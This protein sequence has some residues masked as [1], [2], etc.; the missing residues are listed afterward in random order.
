MDLHNSNVARSVQVKE[1]IIKITFETKWT[2]PGQ[3]YSI[4]AKDRSNA[5]RKRTKGRD[6]CDTIGNIETWLRTWCG[7]ATDIFNPMMLLLV[8]E[9]Y[10]IN[11]FDLEL[12]CKSL[13]PYTLYPLEWWYFPWDHH[14]FSALIFSQFSRHAYNAPR[15]SVSC[16][17][18]IFPRTRFS[19]RGN[20]G[21][22]A[23]CTL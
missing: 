14:Y 10:Q 19:C 4:K 20:A 17:P 3:M 23:H 2:I 9:S 11:P 18:P 6:E 13:S 12:L 7:D 8:A 21:H 16:T 22:I 5:Q 15:V 1:I